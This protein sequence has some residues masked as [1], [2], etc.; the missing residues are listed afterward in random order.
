[1]T[2]GDDIPPVYVV[3]PAYVADGRSSREHLEWNLEWRVQRGAGRLFVMAR[4]G[5]VFPSVTGLCVGQRVN[6]ICMD[7]QTSS[8]IPSVMA[9][10]V[11]ASARREYEYLIAQRGG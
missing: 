11:R 1:M 8:L 4:P 10:T 3:C 9:Q 7:V 6:V 5:W 2:N